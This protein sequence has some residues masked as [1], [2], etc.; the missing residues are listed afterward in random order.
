MIDDP[1]K[2]I[3]LMRQMAAHLPIP[4]RPTGACLR[5]LKAQGL[6]LRRDQELQIKEAFYLGDEGGISCR[7]TLLPGAKGGL[8]ISITHLRIDPGHPLASE[9]RAYQTERVK[10]IAQSEGAGEP[11]QSPTRPP[12]NKKR[13]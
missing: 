3:E 13:G 11:A 2:V 5:V 4:A 7:V 10:N 9:I 1:V 8:V 6:K 12:K